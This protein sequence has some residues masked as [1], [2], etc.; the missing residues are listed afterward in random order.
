M[1]AHL[2]SEEVMLRELVEHIIIPNMNY[3]EDDLELIEFNPLEFIRREME[4]SD[5]E[6][7]RRTASDLLRNLLKFHNETT[8]SLGMEYIKEL[9]SQFHSSPEN[10]SQMDISINLFLSVSVKSK[11]ERVG[12][13]EVNEMLQSEIHD[14]FENEIG[15]IL[16]SFS[17]H[18][19]VLVC[20]ALKFVTLFR[21]QFSA[22]NIVSMIPTI[23][24]MLDE[25]ESFLIRSFSAWTLE[26]FLSIRESNEKNTL[27]LT[28][29]HLQEFGEKLFVVL[30]AIIGEEGD[31]DEGDNEYVMKAIMMYLL[32]MKDNLEDIID[33]ILDSLNNTLARICHN[34]KNPHFSHYLFESV[35]IIV[36][37]GCESESN[38]LAWREKYESIIFE[39]FQE[40]LALDIVEFLPYVFQILS[41]LL[42]YYQDDEE[43]PQ[44]FQALLPPLLT[45]E[46]WERRGN[47]PALVSLLSSY[48]SHNSSQYLMD[49]N[50][51]LPICGIFQV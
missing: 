43:M 20:E 18:H 35:C 7:K 13:V 38:S 42:S 24:S 30:F 17:D 34:P 49:S 27:L 14:Y 11:I 28:P 26:K 10:W 46:C 23:V 51:F 36:R 40:V 19:P 32:L 3:S 21:S 16:D 37:A 4:G 48:I 15:S 33:S 44:Q 50:S 29:D 12:V 47:I 22:D 8:T 41:L 1:Y 9:T 25:S 31:E 2:F 45:P 39:P 6:T 5:L